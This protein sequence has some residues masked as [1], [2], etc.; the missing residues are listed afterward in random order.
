MATE[1]LDQKQLVASLEK[2]SQ[3]S[4]V[5]QLKNAELE[6]VNDQLRMDNVVC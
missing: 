2:A 5:F 3:A 6:K 4:E 1:E